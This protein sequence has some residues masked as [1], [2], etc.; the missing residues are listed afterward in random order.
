MSTRILDK[1]LAIAKQ[2]FGEGY[3]NKHGYRCYHFAFAFERN[4]LIGIGQNGPYQPNAKAIKFS[5]K[6]GFVNPHKRKNR[7]A[8]IDLISRLW[9]KYYIDNRIKLVVLRLNSRNELRSSKP[10]PNCQIVLDAI[11]ISRVWYSNND[12]IIVTR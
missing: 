8:E 2:L 5:D 9:G 11:G 10:C 1:S 7:H 6:F 3:S 4:K 12:G